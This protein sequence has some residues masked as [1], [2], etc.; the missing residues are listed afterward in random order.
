[1]PNRE[2]LRVRR[3]QYRMLVHRDGDFCLRCWAEQILMP[4][5]TRPPEPLLRLSFR[6]PLTQ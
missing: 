3:A 2:Q 4:G 6:E 5:G 1:M